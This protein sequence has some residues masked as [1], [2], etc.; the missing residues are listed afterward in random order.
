MVILKKIIG[1]ALI[2][3]VFVGIATGLMCTGIPLRVVLGAFG[4][5]IGLVSIIGLGAYLITSDR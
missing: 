2:L 4:F 3:S 1:G 5:A